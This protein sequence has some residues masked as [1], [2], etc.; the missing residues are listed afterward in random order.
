MFPRGFH[1]VMQYQDPSFAH[2]AKYFTRTQRP[3]KYYFIDF[4]ISRRYDPA[5]GP[6]LELPIEGG[7]KTVPEFKASHGPCD[8]FPTDVYY[9]GN[10]IRQEFLEVTCILYDHISIF[11]QSYDQR[12]PLIEGVE[13]RYGFEFMKPLVDDMVQNDPKKRPTMDEVVA[14][15]ETIKASLSSWKLRSRVVPRK[16]LFYHGIIHGT[17]HWI[18]RIGFIVR[19]VPPI[20]GQSHKSTSRR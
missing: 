11:T 13:G 4:G 15:F 19:R 8:P 14:R 17:K 6:P 7:D 20:P 12:D 10:L 18:R 3:P 2:S 16:D 1:P 5:D 9:L